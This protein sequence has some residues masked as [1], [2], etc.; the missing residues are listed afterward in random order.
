LRPNSLYSLW[1][2]QVTLQP[3]LVIEDQPCGLADG[4]TNQF[5]SYANGSAEFSVR[6][7]AL[8][9]ST[10]QKMVAIRL[11]YHAGGERASAHQLDAN[12]HIQLMAFLPLPIDLAWQK[13]PATALAAGACC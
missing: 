4:S 9:S 1:C 11:A 12:S 2:T 3:R 8:P 13:L 7:R 6:L 10:P 5:Q